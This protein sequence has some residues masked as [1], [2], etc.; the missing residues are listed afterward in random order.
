MISV[1]TNRF[2]LV[3]KLLLIL[4][5]LISMASCHRVRNHSEVNKIK[6]YEKI[7]N[8]LWTVIYDADDIDETNN[9]IINIVSTLHNE[10]CPYRNIQQKILSTPLITKRLMNACKK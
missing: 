8:E 2:L 5:Y 9:N 7:R 6:L 1:T 10:C 3:E 4:V